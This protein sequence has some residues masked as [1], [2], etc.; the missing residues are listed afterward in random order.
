MWAGRGWGLGEGKGK[1]KMGKKKFDYVQAFC[2]LLELLCVVSK[3]STL[4]RAGQGR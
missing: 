3:Y 1:R 4:H 2:S